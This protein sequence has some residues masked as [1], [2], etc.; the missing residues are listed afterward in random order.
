MNWIL[1]QMIGTSN[2]I[3]QNVEFWPISSETF[4]G[5]QP[6]VAKLRILCACGQFGCYPIVLYFFSSQQALFRIFFLGTWKL[7]ISLS[8]FLINFFDCST[9]R[10]CCCCVNFCKE[11]KWKRFSL[12]IVT[13]T[14]IYFGQKR[15]SM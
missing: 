4:M 8:A 6:L 3:S 11:T 2:W 9:L 12:L 7:Q 1:S 5:H 13:C 15:L 10:V 14:T